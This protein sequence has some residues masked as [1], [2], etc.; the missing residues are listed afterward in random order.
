MDQSKINNELRSILLVRV[1]DFWL[2][3][4]VLITDKAVPLRVT[5]EDALDQAP[6]RVVLLVSTLVELIRALRSAL[7]LGCCATRRP[8][9]R[10][11]A[12]CLTRFDLLRNRA[13]LTGQNLVLLLFDC[14][15]YLA[16]LDCVF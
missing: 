6:L 4:E 9:P 7:V 3:S 1:F 2:L 12:S 16:N 8:L 14:A 5:L 15:A 11:V 10:S 13:E